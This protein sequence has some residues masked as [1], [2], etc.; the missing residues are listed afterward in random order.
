MKVLLVGNYRIEAQW[1]MDR[2]CRMLE[3]G[4][5]DEGVETEVLMPAVVLGGRNKWLG[6]ADK[7][8]LFPMALRRTVKER[9]GW[10]VHILDQGNGMYARSAAGCVVTCH[11]LLAI[12]AARGEFPG[13]RTRWTGRVFQKMI[14]RGLRSAGA[15]VCVSGAT[16][17]DAERLIGKCELIPNALEDFWGPMEAEEA[18]SRIQRSGVCADAR[19]AGYMLHVGGDAWYKNRSEVVRV[20]IELRK[21]GHGLKLVMVGPQPDGTLATVLEEAGLAGEVTVLQAVEDEALRAL[22]AM[23]R[24]LLL[25]SLAEGFGWPILEAQ[26]CGCPVV[27]SNQ[28]PMRETGGDA[29]IY[30]DGGEW[31]KAVEEVLGMTPARRAAFVAAG[32]ENARRFALKK[33]ALAYIEFYTRSLK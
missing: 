4:L 24:V 21:A 3:R 15:I 26:A 20:F 30:A 33:M 8:V 31:A 7:F 29:A 2:F 12:R 13:L 14:L 18:W 5:R 27:T 1:S 19:A 23:A 32:T 22:Y 11:D 6:Y 9:R 17:R 16:R 25:P 10:I 28:D